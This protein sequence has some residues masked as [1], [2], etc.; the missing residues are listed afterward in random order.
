MMMDKSLRPGKHFRK[1]MQ[2]PCL[3]LVFSGGGARGAMQIGAVRALLEAGVKP[4]LLV[5]TSIGAANATGLALWGVD[6][7]GIAV[8]ERTWQDAPGASLLD[9]R[10]SWLFLRRVLGHPNTH[11]S[12]NT[13]QFLNAKGITPD[14]RFDQISGVRLALVGADLVSGQPVIY[15]Q[16]PSQSVLEG[17]L[18][19][20]ALPPWFTAVEK[21]GQYIVD[22]GF[23]SNLP[24]ESALTM[25][26][27][28]IIALDL[29]ESDSVDGKNSN[30]LVQYV[31]KLSVAIMRRQ[32]AL[33]T[34]LAEARGVP[35]HHIELTSAIPTPVWAFNNYSQLITE[36]YEMTRHQIS[37]PDR[38][39][40]VMESPQDLENIPFLLS[41]LI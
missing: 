20:T 1:G 14:L 32:R 11:G 2:K 21:D 13:A 29:G 25:G 31:D 23:L 10:L 7:A 38:S 18:A 41:G 26:A 22:G 28:E 6:L 30:E 37:S 40:P 15:G 35:I 19:S 34:A 8:L 16:D 5:G 33:E 36:G 4:D 12:R 3:A 27:T 39:S 9:R 24:I 17:V